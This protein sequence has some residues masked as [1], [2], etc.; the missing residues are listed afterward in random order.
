MQHPI[1]DVCRAW[2]DIHVFM[3][4]PKPI[5]GT[6]CRENTALDDFCGYCGDVLERTGR[7]I[8]VTIYWQDSTEELVY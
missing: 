3:P 8:K 1:Q 2:K 6:T 5:H 4:L 7:E